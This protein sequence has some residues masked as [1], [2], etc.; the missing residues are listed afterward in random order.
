MLKSKAFCNY[1][2][3]LIIS[4]CL[5]LLQSFKHL[6]KT[7][8]HQVIAFQHSSLAAH[9]EFK[10][11][12]AEV[13]ISSHNLASN[14]VI[15]SFINCVNLTFF[16]YFVTPFVF[17]YISVTSI[18]KKKWISTILKTGF[19]SYTS[20]GAC[21]STSDK[22]KHFTTVVPTL[23]KD[24]A[25]QREKVEKVIFSGQVLRIYHLFVRIIIS[26]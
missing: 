7:V 25:D 9:L 10:E 4:N 16:C 17:Y 3:N 8:A 23:W 11:L 1:S 13:I 26:V 15:F 19:Y 22:N 2:L 5:N 20:Q 14:F 18:E 12:F 6:Q 24:K 21:Y